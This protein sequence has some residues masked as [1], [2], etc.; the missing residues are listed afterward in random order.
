M[1]RAPTAR[2][3][4]ENPQLPFG[5]RRVAMDPSVRQKITVCEQLSHVC[6]ETCTALLMCVCVYV[7]MLG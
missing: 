2:E 7:Y 5:M 6:H 3:I 4:G 1:E